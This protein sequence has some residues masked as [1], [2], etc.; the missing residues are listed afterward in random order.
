MTSYRSVF[1]IAYD[2]LLQLLQIEESPEVFNKLSKFSCLL[3]VDDN[4]E[5]DESWKTIGEQC[6]IEVGEIKKLALPFRDFVVVLD[7]TRTVMIALVD[8]ALPSNT[9]GGFNLRNL[10]RRIF[11]TIQKNGWDGVVGGVPGIVRIM[12][13]HREQLGKLYGPIGP[14]SSMEGILKNEKS[15][16]ELKDKTSSQKLQKFKKKSEMSLDDWYTAITGYGIP[17]NQVEEITGKPIPENLYHFIAE[18]Q[19]RTFR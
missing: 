5:M 10:V 13:R 19:E 8:G 2:Y 16:W 6:G 3:D 12:D 9:G 15:K 7:H 18:R 17:A 14:Y 1:G 4:L 11:S